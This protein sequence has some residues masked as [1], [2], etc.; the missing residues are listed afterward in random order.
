MSWQDKLV[1]IDELQT[2]IESYGPLGPELLRKL[3]YKFRLDW[4]YYSNSMEGNT[5]TLSETRYVMINN[6]TIDGRSLHD[7]MEM[8]GHDKVVTELLQLG[9]DEVNLSESRIKEIHK[10]IMWE[11][12]PDKIKLIG[13]WKIAPNYLFNYRGE[14]FDFAPP[15]EVPDRIHRLIDWLNAEKGKIARQAPG[16]LH[17]VLV[18]FA[19]HLDYVTIHPF[20][21]GNGRTARILTN[22]ILIA[23]GYPPVYV[24][25]DER[26]QYYNYLADVQGY[27]GPPDLFFEYMAGLL[28]RSLQLVLDAIE[29]KE[30]DE[31]DDISKRLKLLSQELQARGD[32]NDVKFQLNKEVFREY[33]LPWVLDLLGES[34]VMVQKFNYLFQSQHHSVNL[35]SFNMI[36]FSDENPGT[37]VERFRREIDIYG[38][39]LNAP[40]IKLYFTANYTS[41]VKGGPSAFD[42]TYSYEIVF[43]K[44]AY[45]IRV[46]FFVGENRGQRREL[47]GR[48]LLHVPLS[49][50]HQIKVAQALGNTILEHIEFH[51]K[52]LGFGV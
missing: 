5:L 30:I 37:I 43:D 32:Q 34:V 27:G 39:R 7:V 23:Y 8:H 16:L 22:L 48:T 41:F 47:I 49:K 24:K 25:T 31:P 17:P 6:L 4:N 36:E 28:I 35:Q 18:A 26:E 3:H 13:R 33:C 45:Q 11:E 44:I 9:K 19:F 46:D 38:D 2:L 20:Y 21:D 40:E 50:E 29:G 10:G 12:D 1:R 14:R 42:C 52:R 15:D 51:S